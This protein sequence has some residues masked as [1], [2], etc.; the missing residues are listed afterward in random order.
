MRR[1]TMLTMRSMI[2]SRWRIVLKDHVGF[3]QAAVPFEVD[4]VVTIDQD[5]G[6]LGVGEERF[7]RPE[8]ENFVEHVDDQRV[9]LEQAQR[10]VLALPIEK[11]ADETADLGLSIFALHSGQ[12]LEIQATE[13]FLVDAPLEGL[14]LRIADIRRLLGQAAEIRRRRDHGKR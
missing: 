3:F 6:D 5:V 4:L 14:I 9:A 8:A 1:P 12:A 7:E 13:Q 10:D 11:I 2:R